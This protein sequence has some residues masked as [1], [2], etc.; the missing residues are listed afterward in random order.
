M[1]NIVKPSNGIED[2]GLYYSPSASPLKIYSYQVLY[3]EYPFQG[4]SRYD[5]AY[6]VFIYNYD[7]Y[8]AS[9]SVQEA[10]I[11]ISNEVDFIL[12]K[13]G[14][15]TKMLMTMGGITFLGM[16]V[17]LTFRKRRKNI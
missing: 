3:G 12:P 17:Y 16:S 1:A 2:A 10:M 9:K 7:D 6:R 13:T 8:D 14:T 5:Y 15:N 4:D 11:E